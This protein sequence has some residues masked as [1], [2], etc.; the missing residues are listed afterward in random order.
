MPNPSFVGHKQTTSAVIQTN[1]ITTLQVTLYRRDCRLLNAV[2]PLGDHKQ[3]QLAELWQDTLTSP[4][5]PSKLYEHGTTPLSVNDRP[6]SGCHR[7]TTAAQDRC[8]GVPHLE[9][10]QQ[11]Q[12]PHRH[13][14][15]DYARFRSRLYPPPVRESTV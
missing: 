3:G 7:V 13:K 10:E 2:L 1:R 12:Q 9:T 4:D 8:I 11:Q 15:Q 5:R 6:M 14:S